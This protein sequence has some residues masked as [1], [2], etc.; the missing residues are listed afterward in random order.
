[1]DSSFSAQTVSRVFWLGGMEKVY[2][3]DIITD[4]EGRELNNSKVTQFWELPTLFLTSL[5]IMSQAP[6]HFACIGVAPPA[7][8]LGGLRATLMQAKWI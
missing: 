3:C 6:I 1:M 5:L 2:A 4:G 7:E 8:C